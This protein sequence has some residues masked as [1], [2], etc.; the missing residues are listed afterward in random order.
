MAVESDD[1]LALTDPFGYEPEDDDPVDD[2]DCDEVFVLRRKDAVAKLSRDAM[3]D[4][5]HDAYEAY[6]KVHG[7]ACKLLEDAREEAMSHL[8]AADD[9]LESRGVDP[10]KQ[11]LTRPAEHDLDG[12]VDFGTE[13][14]EQSGDAEEAV[15]RSRHMEAT[16]EARERLIAQV[17]DDEEDRERARLLV[18]STNKKE[19]E[20]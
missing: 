3:R 7:E 12:L 17:F 10:T 2:R 15:E 6:A 11:T 5:L 8:L 9:W 18:G 1:A 14:D 4:R 19:S 16:R 13:F 20:P